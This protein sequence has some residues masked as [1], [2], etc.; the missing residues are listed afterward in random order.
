MSYLSV[1]EM[2]GSAS[3]QSRIVAAAAGEGVS[4]PLPWVQANIWKLA[5]SPGW[6]DAWSYALGTTTDD[7]NPDT[8]KRPGVINDAMILAAVQANMPAPDPAPEA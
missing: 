5:S 7:E 8:G 2:A 1:V 3:L 6:A 4:D